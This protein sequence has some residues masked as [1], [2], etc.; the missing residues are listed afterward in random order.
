MD[1]HCTVADDSVALVVTS[2]PYF[3]GKEYEQAMGVGHVPADFAAY[4]GM[5]HDV[6]AADLPAQQAAVMA[7]T[8]RPVSE[9]AF[10]EPSGP[11][12]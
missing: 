7:A 4:L 11:P 1:A 2:P 12:A 6:F 8:Q 3:A 10:T 5:L 9:L